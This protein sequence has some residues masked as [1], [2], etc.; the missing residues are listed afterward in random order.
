M[1]ILEEHSFERALFSNEISKIPGQRRVRI[2][3]TGHAAQ[4]AVASQRLTALARKVSGHQVFRKRRQIPP[5]LQRRGLRVTYPSSNPLSPARQSGL[6][7]RCAVCRN[8]CA[9]LEAEREV[10]QS[11][12]NVFLDFGPQTANFAR[13]S[14][15]A[16]LQ[17]PCF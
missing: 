9:V 16:N 15:V 14:L 12:R 7:E 3:C 4:L 17:F 1:L 11:P 2:L 8:T 5:T 10:T 6:C 13:Q